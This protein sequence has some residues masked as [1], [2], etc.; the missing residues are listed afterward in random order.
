MVWVDRAL[1]CKALRWEMA[2][3]AHQPSTS[4]V[5]AGSAMARRLPGIE[6]IAG[7]PPTV[8]V[9]NNSGGFLHMFVAEWDTIAKDDAIVRIEGMCASMCTL[10]M[11][12]ASAAIDR[13]QK[14][15]VDAAIQFR[16]QLSDAREFEQLL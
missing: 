15:R 13:S 12:T 6:V 8:I 5:A 11:A 7:T 2:S 4:H 3:I 16:R 9:T 1:P 10:V 14:A